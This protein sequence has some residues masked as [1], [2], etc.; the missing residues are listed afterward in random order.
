MSQAISSATVKVESN[1]PGAAAKKPSPTGEGLP[2]GTP[3]S[4]PPNSRRVEIN[5]EIARLG[6]L[7]K[8]LRHDINHSSF[9]A[10]DPKHTEYGNKAELLFNSCKQIDVLKIELA[11]LQ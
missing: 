10:M 11:K 4:I 5:K 8:H 9:S 6:A 1:Q 3:M 7:V 2:E